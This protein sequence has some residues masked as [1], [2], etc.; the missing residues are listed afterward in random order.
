[1][2]PLHE[3]D[4]V[5]LHMFKADEKERKGGGVY[6]FTSG[7]IVDTVKIGLVLFIIEKL[8]TSTYDVERK[9]RRVMYTQ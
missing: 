7:D 2:P 9:Y 3:D 6:V 4:S 5:P 8:T 1:M